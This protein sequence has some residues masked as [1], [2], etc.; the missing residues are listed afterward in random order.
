MGKIY[1]QLRL[2]GKTMIRTQREMCIKT[3]AIAMGTNCLA[4]TLSR[5]LRLNGWIRPKS[6][7]SP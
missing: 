1:G 7:R 6:R 4:S 2:E 3:A 5:K